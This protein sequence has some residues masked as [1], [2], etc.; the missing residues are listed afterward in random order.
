[1]KSHN[2]K[3][4][5]DVIQAMLDGQ[6]FF[7]LN[8]RIYYRPGIGFMQDD[9]DSTTFCTNYLESWE[10]WQI[11]PHWTDSI[12][13]KTPVLCW[14]WDDEKHNPKNIIE[15]VILKATR[16]KTTRGTVWNNAEPVEPEE[17]W[18]EDDNE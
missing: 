4:L 5:E 16:Y 2:C 13:D 3:S 11:Q 6:S 12:S 9:E 18:Q 8:E 1:M 15:K 17:C 14:V 7:Y 10:N